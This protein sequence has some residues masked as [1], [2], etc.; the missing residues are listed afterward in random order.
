MADEY[1]L[2][3]HQRPDGLWIVEYEGVDCASRLFHSQAEAWAY[4]CQ[5]AKNS[6]GEAFLK[7][8]DGKIRERNT[9]GNDPFP[10]KG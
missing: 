5:Q 2:W 4:A 1:N 9:Y 6:Q 10:P 3:T 8:V 7:G